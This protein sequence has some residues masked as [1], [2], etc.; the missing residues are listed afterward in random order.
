MLII[1]LR[2]RLSALSSNELFAQLD[3]AQPS[4]YFDLTAV[5]DI[6]T[7]GMLNLLLAM[8][9]LRS[10]KQRVYVD[11]PKDPASVSRLRAM[12]FLGHLHS[13]GIAYPQ[14]PIPPS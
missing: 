11:I 6:N 4:T 1:K 12:H 7:V 9:W 10:R 3:P 8:Q 5:A 13:L 2:D 14:A